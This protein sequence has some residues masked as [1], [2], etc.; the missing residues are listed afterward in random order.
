VVYLDFITMF[1]ISLTLYDSQRITKY[2]STVS[3][4][5]VDF[6]TCVAVVTVVNIITMS[7]SIFGC[8]CITYLYSVAVTVR[9]P[10]YGEVIALHILFCLPRL[11]D[12]SKMQ[13]FV[14]HSTDV[15]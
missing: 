1:Y 3:L 8:I 11:G 10:L 2:Y 9:T 5:E 14:S 12:K 4:I 15:L 6:S 7:W 13:Y